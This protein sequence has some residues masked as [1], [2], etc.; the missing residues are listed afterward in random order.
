MNKR[1]GYLE[2]ML[3]GKWYFVF[4]H[5]TRSR[6]A[7]QRSRTPK[8]RP[9]KTGVVVPRGGRVR[10]RLAVSPP[11]NFR[12]LVLGCIKAKFCKKLC[13]W[14]L[15]PRSRQCTPLHSSKITFFSKIARILPRFTKIF[16]MFC[17]LKSFFLTSAKFLIY[18]NLK[19]WQILT[20]K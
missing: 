2:S 20:N 12:G 17:F 9:N 14:K 1:K 6:T 18:Q 15:S 10:K 5:R 7:R 4:N 19:F 8:P 16:R 13:V 3:K 11:A